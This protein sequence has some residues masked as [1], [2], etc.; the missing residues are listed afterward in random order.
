MT[1][2]LEDQQTEAKYKAPAL[3]KGLDI[4]EVLADNETGL[5]QTEIANALGRT[6]NEIY[7]MLTTLVRRSYIIRS[8]GGDRYKLGLKMFALAHQHPPINR[9]L[10]TARH[11]LCKAALETKQSCHIAL[12]ADGNILVIAAAEAPGPWRVSLRPG[13]T[14]SLWNT[15]LGR[16]IA[17]FQKRDV[18]ELLHKKYRPGRDEEIMSFDEYDRILN[19]VRELGHSRLKSVHLHGLTNLGFPIRGPY[20]NAIGAI[21][22][23]YMERIDHSAVP[24]MEEVVKYYKDLAITISRLYG[25]QISEQRV[26]A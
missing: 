13:A 9:L 24:P 3:E 1:N 18:R 21:G 19:D 12:E 2:S 17:A 8:E 11:M 25:A 4:L 5:S 7:R 20:G 22:C 6:P 16:T 23:L 14:V 10:E 26:P 15:S